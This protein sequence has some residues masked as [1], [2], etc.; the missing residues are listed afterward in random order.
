[1]MKDYEKCDAIDLADAVR[2]KDVSA[3]ELL[4]TAIDRIEK[5]NPQI[6]SVAMYDEVIGMQAIEDMPTTGI[7]SGVPFLLKDLGIM[8]TGLPL[9][10]GSRFF[11]GQV[12]QHD[13]ELVTRYR[14]SGLIIF[15]TTTTPEFGA[16]S[17]TEGLA[18]GAVTRN[19]W[20]LSY[21]SGGSSGGAAASVA[22]G[23]IP[24]AHGGDGGGSLRIPGSA[25]GLFGFKPSRMRNP[26]GPYVGEGWGGLTVDNVIS[27]TVRDSA[28]ALDAT[29]GI[30]VGTPYASPHFEGSFLKAVY[31]APKKLRIGLIT[32]SPSGEAVHQDCI[33]AVAD[34]ARL[35]QS[36]GHEVELTKLPQE[37]D[38]E[39]FAHNM[40]LIIASGIS[41]VITNHEQK[42]G[43]KVTP[44]DLETS[45]YTAKEFAERYSAVDYFNAV[46]LMHTVGRHTG[47]MMEK[48]DVL[49]TPTLTTPPAE[50]GRYAADREYVNHRSDTLKY[51]AFLPYFNASG[52]PAM[53]VPL[54]W[55]TQDIPIGVQF[56]GKL[57]AESLLFSL[58]GQLETERPWFYRRPLM[59]P[60]THKSVP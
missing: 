5:F 56:V 10:N 59:H 19:P 8:A 51:T 11:K 42:T 32:Q 50:I 24:V 49:L 26:M 12:S 34:V 15:G 30:D 40:R 38:Y 55:N 60:I 43:I 41:S 22:S 57:G 27:R 9:T 58:A 47:K 4:K 3:Q 25:C 6:N 39:Q 21:S 16:N 31:C 46:S 14:K 2:K 48:Y 18:Y 13:S 17:T 20:N 44:D 7:F 1:M 53:T 29:H 33:D 45:I 37:I 54:C 28:A 35:C 52:Q 36:L 23:I